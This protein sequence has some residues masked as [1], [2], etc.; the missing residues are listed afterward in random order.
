MR[1][2]LADLL[3]LAGALAIPFG[4]YEIY[5]PAGY[6]AIGIMMLAIGALLHYSTAKNSNK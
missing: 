3:I 5:E 1:S 4:I 6:I 2:I